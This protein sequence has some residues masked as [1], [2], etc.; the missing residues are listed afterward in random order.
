LAAIVTRVGQNAFVGADPFDWF[1]LIAR[2]I[3]YCAI[4]ELII[5]AM[6]LRRLR[7][8]NIAAP[9]NLTS[10]FAPS[11]QIGF[12]VHKRQ[13]PGMMVRDANAALPTA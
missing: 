5:G 4:T 13:E 8:V 2:I 7:R 9:S 6:A 3:L 10:G 1:N 12:V 11:E